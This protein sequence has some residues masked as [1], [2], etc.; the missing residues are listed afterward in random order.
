ML[1]RNK[2]NNIESKTFEGSINKRFKLV[3]KI[4]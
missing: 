1:T 4:L 2:L 3:M